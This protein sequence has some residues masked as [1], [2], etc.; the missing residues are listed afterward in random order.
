MIS[1]KKRVKNAKK[2]GLFVICEENWPKKVQKIVAFLSFL[3]EQKKF[4]TSEILNKKLNSK[5]MLN[6]AKFGSI[7]KIS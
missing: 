7:L 6:F 4:I 3:H 5:W 2:N 1:S